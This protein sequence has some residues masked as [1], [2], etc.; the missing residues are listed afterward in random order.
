MYNENYCD[1]I[2]YLWENVIM[3]GYDVV[4]CSLYVFKLVVE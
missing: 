3:E 2:Y 1:D 4:I